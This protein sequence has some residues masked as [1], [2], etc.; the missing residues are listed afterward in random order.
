MLRS[1]LII[2][3]AIVTHFVG[4]NSF[5]KLNFEVPKQLLLKQLI[6]KQNP[7]GNW[8]GQLETDPSVDAMFLVLAKRAGKLSPQLMTQTIQRL[9]VWEQ[10]QVGWGMTPGRAPSIDVTE[11]ILYSMKEVG[12]SESD[13]VFS[14]EWNW[15]RSKEKGHKT[16]DIYAMFLDALG[17]KKGPFPINVDFFAVPKHTPANIFNVGVFRSILV[18]LAVLKFYQK[19]KAKAY[20]PRPLD[21]ARVASKGSEFG[22]VIEGG[23]EF[24]AQEGLGWILAHQQNDGPWYTFHATML[25]ILAFQEAQ[26]LGV[27]NFHSQIELAWSGLLSWRILDE[28][29]QTW[30]VAPSQSEGWDSPLSLLAILDSAKG[31]TLTAEELQSV[32]KGLGWMLQVQPRV[33]GDWKYLAPKLSPGGWSFVENNP[34]YPDTDVTGL[35]LETLAKAMKRSEFADMNLKK[36]FDAGLDWT[37]G[38]QNWDGGF[39][40]W[41][42]KISKFTA[43]ISTLLGTTP[44]L[45]I[46]QVDLSAR[47]IREFKSILSTGILSAVQTKKVNAS[48]QKA[49]RY[50]KTNAESLSPPLWFGDWAVNY[51]YATSLASEAL[52]LGKCAGL[53]EV[54]P[55]F[56]WVVANQNSDGGWGEDVSSYQTKSFVRA[57]SSAGLTVWPLLALMRY[58]IEYQKIHKSASEFRPSIERAMIYLIGKIDDKGRIQEKSFAGV[59][60]KGLWLINYELG[61]SQVVL[62]IMKEYEELK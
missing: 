43:E 33:D 32:R 1:F 40:S 60:V 15:Y 19:A 45:D 2:T 38:M 29:S 17:Y 8:K 5:A 12:I 21:S 13:T 11:L 62:S 4:I 31:R 26:S 58:E 18:P 34:Y 57:E 25:G 28:A 22:K 30:F 48:I 9:K 10:G 16:A 46:G 3:I 55:S 36:S 41:D 6:A 51:N 35:S 50:I 24:W 52:L 27:A 49:C 59:M 53:E 14:K 47:L 20:Y 23:A 42:R 54:Y 61:P 7:S 37:L 39:P 56:L 44:V